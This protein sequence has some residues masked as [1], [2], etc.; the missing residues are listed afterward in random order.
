MDYEQTPEQVEADRIATTNALLGF[1]N[2]GAHKEE[3]RENY[4]KS[5]W[6]MPG[7]KIKSL[8]QILPE[9]PYR[10]VWIDGCVGTGVV[11]LN[12]R[13]SKLEILNDRHAGITDLFRVIRDP[14]MYDALLDRLRHVVHSREEFIWCRNTWE[15]HYD[16]VERAAR[17]YYMIRVSFNQIGR[18]F[19]RATS[20]DSMIARKYWNGLKLLAPIHNRFKL[21]QIE[22]LDVVQCLK[23]FDSYNT[24]GYF[25]P[26]YVDTDQGIYQHGV[27]HVKFLDAVMDSK[28]F[29]VVSG[30]ENDLYAGYDWDKVKKWEVWTPVKTQATKT[31]K[32]KG[33]DL[34]REIA[35]EVL[36]I[37]DL[38]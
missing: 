16:P 11:S 3:V 25:D 31:G 37:K 2:L 5:A 6:N 19:G 13:E 33:Q 20:G 17:W 27:D 24:V 36:Y 34:K 18:N 21:C 35:V 29:Y 14:V 12:R 1:D 30:Y 7:G 28:G 22:N 26:D 9:L 23:D 38:R 8:H 32:T 15:N 4:V 10:D